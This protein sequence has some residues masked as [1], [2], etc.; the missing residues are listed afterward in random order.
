MLYFGAPQSW[1]LV[2]SFPSTHQEDPGRA[3]G[4]PLADHLVTARQAVFLYPQ[5]LRCP[6]SEA[7]EALSLD[8]AASFL[9]TLERVLAEETAPLGPAAL[10]AVVHFLK[11][12]TA[13][14]AGELEHLTGPWEQLGQ[15]VVSVTSLVLDEQLAGAW[16]SISEVR[17]ARLTRGLGSG[18]ALSPAC[19]IAMDE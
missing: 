9:G 10:L 18:L 11:R 1:E 2:T 6:L 8:K 4:W 7:P 14:G 5:L 16:L 19:C 17:L 15:G 13:L 12:V 3:Q